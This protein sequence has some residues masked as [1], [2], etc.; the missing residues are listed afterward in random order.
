[1]QWPAVTSAYVADGSGSVEVIWR[2][3]LQDAVNTWRTLLVPGDATGAWLIGATDLDILTIGVT[4]INGLGVRGPTAYIRH[5]VVGK[6][7]APSNVAGLAYTLKPGA[8]VWTWTPPTDNDYAQTEARIGGSSWATAA[9]PA[10]FIGRATT[11]TQ[12]VTATGTYTLRVKHI[13]SSGIESTT[14]AAAAAVVATGDLIGSSPFNALLTNESAVVAADSFGTVASFSAAGGELQIWLGPSRVTSG[15]TYS[16]FSQTGVSVSINSSTGAY[17][18]SS[19]SADEGVATLRAVI[20]GGATLDKVYNIA[21]SKTGAAGSAGAA[22]AAGA[23]GNKTAIAYLYQ[24]SGGT[25]S[26]PNSSSTFTWATVSNGTYTGSNGWGTAFPANPFIAGGRLWVAAKAISDV[27]SASSTSVSWTGVT[28]YAWSENGADGSAGAPGSP[29]SPGSSGIDAI[30]GMLTNEAVVFPADSAG[31]VTSYAGNVT[32][33]KIF[34]GITDV[35]TLGWTF[36]KVDSSGVSST[37]SANQITLNSISAGT[38]A[39]YVDITAAQFGYASITKRYYVSKASAGAT[40][41]TGATGAAGSTGAAG[42]RGSIQVSALISGSSWSDSSANAAISAAGYGSPQTLDLCVLYNA[43]GSYSETR[44]YS[45]GAWTVYAARVDGNLVVLGSITT[46]KLV[47]NAATVAAASGTSSTLDTFTSSTTWQ[48]SWR[49]ID[50]LTSTGSPVKVLAAVMVDFTTT[51]AGV[52]AV[53][54]TVVIGYG[55]GPTS[56]R[57]AKTVM[58]TVGGAARGGSVDSQCLATLPIVWRHTPAAGANA[59]KYKVIVEILDSTGA[60][61]TAS[62]GV[63]SFCDGL[64]EENKV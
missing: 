60:L 52:H 2:R 24:W 39:G 17:T 41:S 14:A 51:T 54:I 43:A 31:A 32:E 59:Y 44:V 25:P 13:D 35:T 7:Q 26:G 16:V 33:L 40:G 21:K 30:V 37:L 20:S 27:A 53:A 3:V 1:V 5:L 23:D 34:S 18:I 55:S 8:I 11:F 29:G 64:F 9:T 22:G 48:S 28:P 6:T 19:M 63:Q 49:T 15:V 38:A 56:L 57:S 46:D 42:I 10:A 61:M 62:G 58:K 47:A 45:S 4:A 36:S 50:T 12:P